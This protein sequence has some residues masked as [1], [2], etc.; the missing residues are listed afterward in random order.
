MMAT[1]SPE[2]TANRTHRFG[3]LGLTALVA[4]SAV[5]GFVSVP[6]TAGSE[7]MEEK[8]EPVLDM[9]YAQV[10]KVQLVMIPAGVTDKKGRPVAGLTA[11]DFSLTV[12][13]QPKTIEFFAT[14]SN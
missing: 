1:N 6:A 5:A 11:R 7:S 8:P 2:K 9:R 12:D 3:F 4:F 13:G 10:E 14:E